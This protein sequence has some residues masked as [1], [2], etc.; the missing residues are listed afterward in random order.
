[1]ECSWP[2]LSLQAQDR[3][4]D[5]EMYK[6]RDST[7]GSERQL[8]ALLPTERASAWLGLTGPHCLQVP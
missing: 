5:P 6:E 1:M 2:S 7:K 8:L 4:L 3:E